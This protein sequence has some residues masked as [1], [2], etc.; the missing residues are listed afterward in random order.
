MSDEWR[1]GRRGKQAIERGDAIGLGRRDRESPGN[2]VERRLADPADA[3]LDRVQGRQK[4]IAPGT[5]FVATTG[6]VAVRSGIPRPTAPAGL[7]R[8]QDGVN[9]RPLGR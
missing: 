9:G 5:S 6:D 3:G 1:P 2:I 7:R 8:A 4:E